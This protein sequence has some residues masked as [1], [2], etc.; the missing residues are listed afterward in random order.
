MLTAGPVGT[1]GIARTEN[2]RSDFWAIVLVVAG[3]EMSGSVIGGVAKEVEARVSFF[4]RSA[5]GFGT[6]LSGVDGR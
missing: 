2:S 3:T 6:K 4:L 5:S 1:L